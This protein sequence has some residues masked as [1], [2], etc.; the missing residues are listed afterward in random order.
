MSMQQ[1]GQDGLDLWTRDLRAV[2]GHFDT[3]LAFN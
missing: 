2:C 3:E 1:I